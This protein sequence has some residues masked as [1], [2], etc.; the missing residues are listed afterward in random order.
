MT[1]SKQSKDR[2]LINLQLDSDTYSEI[3]DVANEHQLSLS[4]I[5]NWMLKKQLNNLNELM[6]KLK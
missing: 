1:L 5:I 6:D 3:K 4:W 2:Q